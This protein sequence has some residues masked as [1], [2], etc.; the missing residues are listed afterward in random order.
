M[1]DDPW[2]LGALS[3]VGAKN[4]WGKD[5]ISDII[6]KGGTYSDGFYLALDGFSLKCAW[7]CAPFHTHYRLRRRHDHAFRHAA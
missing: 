3:F 4:N 1:L 7:Q 6:A 2:P 5:E